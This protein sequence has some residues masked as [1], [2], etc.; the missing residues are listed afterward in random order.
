M[1]ESVG[2]IWPSPSPHRTEKVPGEMPV[3]TSGIKVSAGG[4]SV[5][6][7]LKANFPI[8]ALKQCKSRVLDLLL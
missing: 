5:L 2:L 8:N 3:G 1:S 6:F 4:E 7:K